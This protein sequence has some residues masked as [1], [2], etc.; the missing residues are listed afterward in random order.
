MSIAL[1]NPLR[2]GLYLISA[3]NHEGQL[4]VSTDDKPEHKRV[5][6]Y[7][8]NPDATGDLEFDKYV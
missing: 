7:V 4:F 5:V 1:F 8:K 2:N 3:S 6:A